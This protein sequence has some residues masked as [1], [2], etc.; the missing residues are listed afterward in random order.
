MFDYFLVPFPFCGPG[1]CLPVWSLP[2]P[3]AP[4]LVGAAVC[5]QAVV[6]APPA[7]P[8]CVVATNGIKVTLLP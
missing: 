7:S 6:L 8:P 3:N 1:G 5:A 2:I 4:A